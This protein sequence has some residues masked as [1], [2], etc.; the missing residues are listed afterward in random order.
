MSSQANFDS[1]SSLSSYSPFSPF[2][3]FLI[4]TVLIS[5]TFLMRSHFNTVRPGLAM[6]QEKERN[7]LEDKYN[8]AFQRREQVVHHIAWAK[9][10]GE[11]AEVEQMKKKCL[12][13]DEDIDGLEA[14]IKKLYKDHGVRAKAS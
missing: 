10:R 7:A 4:F 12:Q 9:Q 8:N 14:K 2:T 6:R 5:Y 1:I 3:T 13:I 11:E